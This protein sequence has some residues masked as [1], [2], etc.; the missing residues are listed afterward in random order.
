[1]RPHRIRVLCHGDKHKE[2]YLSHLWNINPGSA[3]QGPE[4]HL[5][6]ES[7]EGRLTERQAR[8]TV[9]RPPSEKPKQ[10]QRWEISHKNHKSQSSSSST[11]LAGIHSQVHKGKRG[12]RSPHLNDNYNTE[13]KTTELQQGGGE[14]AGG[15][16]SSRSSSHRPLEAL[17]S[18]SRKSHFIKVIFIDSKI[19]YT[20]C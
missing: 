3:R 1:M 16:Q 2:E 18:R 9:R 5:E 7:T 8:V 11:T 12:N 6:P 4:R 14:G 10:R 15:W 19:K 17:K 20:Q 13:V